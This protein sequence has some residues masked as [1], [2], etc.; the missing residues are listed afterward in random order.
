MKFKN[1]E[2]TIKFLK[3]RGKTVVECDGKCDINNL[4]YYPDAVAYDEYNRLIAIIVDDSK[5]I[6]EDRVAALKALAAKDSCI[7]FYVIEA[8]SFMRKPKKEKDS[9]RLGY[10][11]P[12]SSG[13]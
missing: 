9:Y 12:F 7:T 8:P 6:D 2:E 11:G 1:L 5:D 3:N 4:G 13:L 10:T